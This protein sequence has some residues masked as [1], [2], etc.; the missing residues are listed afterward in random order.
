MEVYHV[1]DVNIVHLHF[2][3]DSRADECALDCKPLNSFVVEVTFVCLTCE[4]LIVALIGFHHFIHYT[5]VT[6]SELVIIC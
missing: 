1:E 3:V 4:D 2:D 6:I 5:S